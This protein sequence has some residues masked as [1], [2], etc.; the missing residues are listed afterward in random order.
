MKNLKLTKPIAFIDIETTGLNTQQDRIIEICVIKIHPSGAEEILN[1][2]IN[3][4]IPIPI[5]STQIH[6]IKDV[7]VEGK[8]TFNEFAKEL[9]NFIVNCD[10]GGFGT[11]FDLSFLES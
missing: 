2:I 1:S 5:E 8:P 10:L 3:P 4:K 7:D 9:I 6:G 11:K